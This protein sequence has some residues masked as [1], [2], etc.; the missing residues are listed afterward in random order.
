[1]ASI[2]YVTDKKMI[3]FHRLNGNTTMNFWRLSNRRNFTDFEKGDYLFFLAKGTER[4][5]QREKGIVGY[6]KLK[7]SFTSSLKQMWKDFG[8]KNGYASETEFIEAISKLSKTKKIPKQM[9]GLYLEEVRFFHSPVYLS[10]IGVTISNKIESFI[11]L[12]KEDLKV[13]TKILNEAKEVGLDMW[14]IAVSDEVDSEQAFLNDEIS[15]LL[16]VAATETSFPFLTVV[17]KKKSI[18]MNQSY[19]DNG[20]EVIKGND[21]LLMKHE[22]QKLFVHC[23]ISC[24][25]KDKNKMV[26]TIIGW[27]YMID[28]MFSTICPYKIPLSFTLDCEHGLSEEQ[29]RSIERLNGIVNGK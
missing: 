25:Q 1:M 27:F 21:V 11:Y 13:T 17:E 15:H 28:T 3:E 4:G 18:K 23:S 10:E 2:A 5:K 14:T 12:D 24:L 9:N 6:G 29:V 16:S 26:T 8:S 7:K 19:I 20:F 22:A